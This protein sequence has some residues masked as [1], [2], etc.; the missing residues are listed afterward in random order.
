MGVGAKFEAV[1]LRLARRRKRS[2]EPAPLLID[3][4]EAP[5]AGAAIQYESYPFLYQVHDCGD[6]FSYGVSCVLSL[7]ERSALGIA[8][9]EAS[10]SLDPDTLHP[11]T[12][13]N[14]VQTLAQNAAAR[15]AGPAGRAPVAELAELAA[16]ES[17][18]LPRILALAKD[19]DVSEY[20][21]DSDTTCIYL[22]HAK[23]GRCETGILLTE[24]E[25][26]ALETHLDTFRG[27][28]PDY[29]TPSLKNDLEISGARL[30]VSLD[31]EPVSVNRFALD[32]RRLNNSVF[33]IQQLI[34]LGV[35]TL[36]AAALL[37]GWLEVGGNCTIIGETGSGKTTL[38][39]ALD[40]RV[41]RRLRRLYIEDAVETAD[42]LSMGFHQMKV[43]VDPFE[44]GD[45]SRTKETEIVK[46]LHRSPDIVVLSELQSR[47][48]SSAFFQSLAAGVRG[49]QTFHASTIEQA[50]R[51]WVSLHGVSEES[52]LDLGVLVL[53][54]RPDRLRPE[55]YLTRI[56]HVYPESGRPRLRE[57]F[58]RD[59]SFS[60]VRVGGWE[61]LVS[62]GG[63]ASALD[64]SIGRAME[65]LRTDVR[66]S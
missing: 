10:A 49:I 19:K 1:V 25:R 35:L 41:D 51:R 32:V 58:L 6:H 37:I 9:S 3:L 59:K 2:P 14:L 18:G 61:R 43:K 12:F 63:A 5:R 50:F 40:E 45:A 44:R 29:V 20:F 52:L 26:Q 33:S 7:G 55:R 4:L 30:R 64:S 62:P 42:L 21:V 46:A 57:M 47:E 28:T 23:V 34:Q 16:Y 15:L 39:N 53:M 17:I 65:R 8:V 60:L 11:L 24:R 54:S 38:L 56:C 27:Y 13:D 48:H 31:L 22:D 36:E 66:Q